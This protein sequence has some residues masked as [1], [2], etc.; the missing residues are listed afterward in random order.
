MQTL[1]KYRIRSKKANK[2][3]TIKDKSIENNPCFL[4]E[5]SSETIYR[6]SFELLVK[7]DNFL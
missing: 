7:S 1:G 6:Q 2:Y 5:K 4:Y 3:I